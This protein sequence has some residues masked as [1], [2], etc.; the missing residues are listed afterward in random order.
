[1]CVCVCVCCSAHACA[2]VFVCKKPAYCFIFC[3]NGNA[4]AFVYAIRCVSTRRATK[5][6]YDLKLHTRRHYASQHIFSLI[7]FRIFSTDPFV[8]NADFRPVRS[9]KTNQI[10]MLYVCYN[11]LFVFLFLVSK[12]KR[13]TTTEHTNTIYH[14]TIYKFAK[15]VKLNWRFLLLSIRTYTFILVYGLHF[16]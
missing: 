7:S 14:T 3:I 12:N 13:K 15:F 8:Y 11:F 5:C 4:V 9:V 10:I 6:L 16:A 2:H 1:M